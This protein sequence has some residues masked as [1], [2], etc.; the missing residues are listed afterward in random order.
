MASKLLTA[1]KIEFPT[2]GITL[3]WTGPTRTFSVSGDAMNISPPVKV[4]LNKWL[5]RYSCALDGVSYTSDLST[6]TML[7][8]GAPDLT[9][10]LR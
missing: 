3:D 2:A 10:R 5:I 7:L 6:V 1:Q 4:T 9:V 8:S